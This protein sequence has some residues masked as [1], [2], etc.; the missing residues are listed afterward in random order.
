MRRRVI[1]HSDLNN[2][3]A[4]IEC[5]HRPELREQPM[6][7]GGSVEKRHGVILAKNELAKRCGVST[8][9][10]LWQ[11]REKCPGLVIVPPNFELYLRFCH[12]VQRIYADYTDFVEPFGLDESWLDISLIARDAAAGRQVA[13][14]ISRRIKQEL[15][16]T[17]SI[18]VA[19]NKIFA[20]LGSDYKKPDAITVITEANYRQLLWPLPAQALLGVGRSGKERLNRH[21]IFTIGQIAAAHPDFLHFIFGSK[22]GEMLHSYANGRDGSPV[23]RLDAAAMVKSISNSTTT[24]RDLVSDQDVRLVMLMLAESVASRLR[25][26]GLYASGVGIHLRDTALFSLERQGR[27]ERPSDLAGELLAL[28]MRLFATAYGHWPRP[29]RSLGLQAFHLS[30]GSGA[31]QLD[32]FSDEEKRGKAERLAR[33]VDQIRRR[34]GYQSVQPASLLKDEGLQIQDDPVQKRQQIGFHK[35]R[36]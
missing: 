33:S 7:V 20:K 6:A 19:D 30:D 15:G 32:L 16:L 3:Y 4:S 36:P 10:P 34:F 13:E 24:P 1:L 8:G 22:L 31:I 17:V 14:E 11:A 23:K 21:G 27:L 9:E 2:C 26:Q 18:G 5:L 29:L 12:M 28:A 25:E 35:P